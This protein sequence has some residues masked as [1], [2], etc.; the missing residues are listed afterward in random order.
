M[1]SLLLSDYEL[2]EDEPVLIPPI[3]LHDPALPLPPLR[4]NKPSPRTA[5]A[6]A[7]AIVR[8]LASP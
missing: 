7:D 2:D 8:D 6:D 4:G 5:Q 1:P 3:S